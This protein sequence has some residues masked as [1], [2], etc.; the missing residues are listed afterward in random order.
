M[1]SEAIYC[2]KR[3][4]NIGLLYT[5]NSSFDHSWL[6][7]LFNQSEVKKMRMHA[8]IK[9]KPFITSTYH[10]V[11]CRWCDRKLMRCHED[12]KTVFPINEVFARNYLYK[13]FLVM[14]PKVTWSFSP[15]FV[16]LFMLFLIV[17]LYVYRL[18]DLFVIY[19]FS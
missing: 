14:R 5:N 13:L 8:L 1:F 19:W 7:L 12:V 6:A 16:V 4:S 3:I 11:R 17:C 9:T 2:K 15:D 10:S 18:I